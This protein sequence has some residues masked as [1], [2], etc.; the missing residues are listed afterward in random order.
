MLHNLI[1]DKHL[2]KNQTIH[3]KNV[4]L[5]CIPVL[6]RDTVSSCG[7]I[8]WVQAADGG[9]AHQPVS[10]PRCPAWAAAGGDRRPHTL[11]G[12]EAAEAER[13]QWPVWVDV[14]SVAFVCICVCG[15][16]EVHSKRLVICDSSKQQESA[17]LMYLALFL[18]FVG[19]DVRLPGALWNTTLQLLLLLFE[20][21]N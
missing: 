12:A 5:S 17:F 4:S 18:Y 6:L 19:Y 16:A 8:G 15:K 11:P 20:L 1:Y 21:F 14:Q 13:S 9:P 3:V 7:L 2:I 10:D